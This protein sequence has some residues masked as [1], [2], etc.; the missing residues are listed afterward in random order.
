MAKR[1]RFSPPSAAE[2]SWVRVASHFW[3]MLMIKA[4]GSAH[5][6][7]SYRMSTRR[8]HIVADGDCEGSAGARTISVRAH[9]CVYTVWLR[10]LGYSGRHR[11][12]ARSA[13]R[14]DRSPQARDLISILFDALLWKGASRFRASLRISPYM[15]H[16][17]QRS[18]WADRGARTSAVTGSLS[19]SP[20]LL[21]SS[22]LTLSL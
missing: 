11:C 10:A 14:G 18:G 5:L 21:L 19:P 22:I 13:P 20:P 6:F 7:A 1:A 4:L 12:S 8:S 15:G 3:S 9:G 2:Y 17:E 16:D